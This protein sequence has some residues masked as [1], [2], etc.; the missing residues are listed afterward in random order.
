MKVVNCVSSTT[1]TTA[2]IPAKKL[3]VFGMNFGMTLG[4]QKLLPVFGMKQ[5]VMTLGGARTLHPEHA[6]HRSRTARLA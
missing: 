6:N 1:V 2:N 3:P 4:A 5:N